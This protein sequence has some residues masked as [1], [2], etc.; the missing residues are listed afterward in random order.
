LRI[1]DPAASFDERTERLVG[2]FGPHL[3]TIKNMTRGHRDWVHDCMLN[4]HYLHVALPLETVFDAVGAE[5]EA[6]GT[7]PR[8]TLDWR[9]FKALAGEGRDFNNHTLAAY[10][11]NVHNFID[12]RRV[13]A[14]TEGDNKTLSDTF[15]QFYAAAL[16]WQQAFNAG[17]DVRSAGRRIAELLRDI[18]AALGAIDRDIAAAVQEACAVWS[19]PAMSAEDVRDMKEFSG[20]FGR[21]TVYISFTRPR[22]VGASS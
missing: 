22:E 8:F 3:A 20:L 7:L 19:K 2:V 10:R 21:E 16:D 1:D 6:L 9:W 18:A 17:T 5:L 4:P 15:A 14:P 13:F 12:Y 11:S